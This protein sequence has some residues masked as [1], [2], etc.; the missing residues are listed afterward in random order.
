MRRAPAMWGP[1]PP[2]EVPSKSC[3]G[4]LTWGRFSDLPVILFPSFPSSA[5]PCAS[6]LSLTSHPPPPKHSRHCQS[7]PP[8]PAMPGASERQQGDRPR[9]R[10]PRPAPIHST[11]D[12]ATNRQVAPAWSPPLCGIP[13][14]SDRSL[15]FPPRHR[16]PSNRDCISV[17]AHRPASATHHPLAISNF[18]LG[19][20]YCPLPTDH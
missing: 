10:R 11:R 15:V 7:S 14:W 19:K 3:H 13:I 20:S 16:S 1:S 17:I 8:D 5:S 4:A 18:V 2:V 12:A 6:P 9:S